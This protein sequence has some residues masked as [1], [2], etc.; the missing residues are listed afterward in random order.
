V[1]IF[2]ELFEQAPCGYL[3]LDA[4][5]TT[6]KVNATLLG[7]LGYAAD[8]VV[9]RRLTDFLPV[10]GRIAFETHLLPLLRLQGSCYEIAFDLRKKDGL[11]LPVMISAAEARASDTVKYIKVTVFQAVQR[12]QFER[13][14]VAAREA[15]EASKVSLSEQN[16]SLRTNI[17]RAVGEKR[18]AERGLQEEQE[19]GE[20]REQFVAVL[21][22]DL[23]N[24]LASISA[25]ARVLSREQTSDRAVQVLRLMEGSVRRM[26][27]LIDNVLDFARGRLGG[28]IGLN[29]TSEEPLEPVLRQVVDELKAGAPDREIEVDF[30]LS[31]PL[32]CDPGRI[33]QLLSNLLGNA[34]SHGAVDRP[35]K[36]E[37]RTTADGDLTLSVANAGD[38][39][40]PASMERLFQPFVRG[41]DRGYQQGL[42]LGLH[43]ASEIAKAH[44]ATLSVASSEDETRF[45]LFLSHEISEP[46]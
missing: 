14:L 33:G 22:H 40:S 37:A 35:I 23:R 17:K 6:E 25:A 7:W 31:A 15:S 38:P 42:G 29:L 13:G 10:T 32:F 27:G 4:N 26:S 12:Q 45:T 41:Q 30:D 43:I 5:G 8:E 20:L 19:T 3:V 16:E 2:E 44:G 21:G 1:S 34:L 24:P 18:R 46:S 36:V 39:I 11:K 28:G 9:G